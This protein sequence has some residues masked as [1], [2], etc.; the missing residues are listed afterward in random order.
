MVFNE[1]SHFLQLFFVK[2]IQTSKRD[3]L[4]EKCEVLAKSTILHG[5]SRNSP[6][7]GNFFLKSS[8]KA[9]NVI[10]CLKSFKFWP[11]RNFYGKLANFSGKAFSNLIERH[12]RDQSRN[13]QLP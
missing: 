11:D 1:M 5:F 2:F 12:S 13:Q 6:L 9:Q 3:S 8:S 7:F 4:L 10:V